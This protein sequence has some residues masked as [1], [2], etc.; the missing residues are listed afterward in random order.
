MKIYSVDEIINMWNGENHIH[1]DQ[2][3]LECSRTPQLHSKYIKILCLEKSL[4]DKRRKEYEIL[5]QRKKEY[6]GGKFSQQD[7]QETG[8][9]LFDLKLLKNEIPDYLESDS[10]LQN[11]LIRMNAQEYKVQLV[12]EIIKQINGRNWLIR[13]MI[14]YQKLMNG[15]I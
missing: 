2:L 11:S 13:N 15:L 10:D 1:E 4:L 9:D 3:S 7:Y 8:W 14:E 12:D 5:K 6:Y